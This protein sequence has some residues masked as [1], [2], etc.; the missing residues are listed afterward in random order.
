MPIETSIVQWTPEDAE[1]ALATQVRNRELSYTTCRR[2]ANDMAAGRWTFD[3]SPIRFDTHGRLIDGQHR[4]TALASLADSS[5]TVPFLVIT[6]LPTGSQMVMDQGRVRTTG[7]QL[8]MNGT[9]RANIVSAG[10]RLYL[11]LRHGVL[12]RDTK[13]ANEVVTKASVEQWVSENE[14]V[15]AYLGTFIGKLTKTDAPPSVAYCAAILFSERNRPAAQEFFTLLADGAGDAT[16]PITVLDKRLQRHRRE[17]IK[18]SN[19]DT[20]GLYIQAWNA[21]RGGRTLTKFQRPRNGSWTADTF[22]KPVR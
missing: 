5:I 8:A 13:L 9:K 20:L 11:V 10:V 3:A 22:P 15:V 18:I 19:R 12:F 7:Q 14:E 1:A 21:W 4:M 6:G 16:H 17:G 2:Y